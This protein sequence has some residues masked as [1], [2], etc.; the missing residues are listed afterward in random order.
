MDVIQRLKSA[1][2]AY[3]CPVWRVSGTERTGGLPI[4]VLFYGAIRQNNY[5]IKKLF[6]PEGVEREYIG[7][8]SMR[9]VESQLEEHDCSL[10][11]LNGHKDV[12]D[13]FKES[14]D[15]AVPL[16][17]E[18]EI[19]CD[20]ILGGQASPTLRREVRQIQ[21]RGLTARQACEDSD[22]E[23]FYREVYLP[24][25]QKSHQDAALPSSIE[26][27]KKMIAD[28]QG[29]TA[30]GRTRMASALEVYL[31]D[32]RE[33]ASFAARRRRVERRSPSTC[34]A[35]RHNRCK[36]LLGEASSAVGDS[37]T[38]SLGLARGFVSDGVFSYKTK[39][40]PRIFCSDQKRPFYFRAPKAGRC[41][42]ICLRARLIVSPKRNTV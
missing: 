5:L 29:G 14:G 3:S 8:R 27:R 6:S 2:R 11:V 15:L 17:V 9:S 42:P 16:W 36:L 10:A 34:E 18:A 23:F 22:I 32:Y 21:E 13:R 30:P 33:H 25:I 39:Y 40:A 35:G 20:R 1:A 7:R 38:I 19:D 4:S 28:G 41:R 24:T 37:S 26:K 12:L 31:L